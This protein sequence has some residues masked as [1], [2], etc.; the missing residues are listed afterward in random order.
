MK[1]FDAYEISGVK[2]DEEGFCE[3]ITDPD[4]R[5]D[6]WSLYGHIEGEGVRC[7][8]DFDSQDHAVEV[9]NLIVGEDAHRFPVTI[10]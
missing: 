10:N 3:V 1:R 6:F 8:G 4:I 9:Y 5:P 7:I 2:K